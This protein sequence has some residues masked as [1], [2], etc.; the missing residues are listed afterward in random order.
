VPSRRSAP[1]FHS[2]A[3]AVN[4]MWSARHALECSSNGRV[5]RP[6]GWRALGARSE[7]H[8]PRRRWVPDGATAPASAFL[9]RHRRSARAAEARLVSISHGDHPFALR[10][11]ARQQV[12]SGRGSAIDAASA[13]S[14]SC[15]HRL[16]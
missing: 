13:P 1:G 5:S 4:G 7:R 3:L 12:V 16:A 9:A 11:P 8:G 15:S 6:V 10:R 14:S 2:R